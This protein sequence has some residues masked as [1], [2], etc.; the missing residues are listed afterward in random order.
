MANV[1][2][3]EFTT[4]ENRFYE[5]FRTT[6]TTHRINAPNF[7][8]Q[9]HFME[10]LRRTLLLM[11]H[12]HADT[13][14]VSHNDM[15]HMGIDCPDDEGNFFFAQVG[16]NSVTIGDCLNGDGLHTILDYFEKRMQSNKNFLFGVG[17]IIKI[18]TF[19]TPSQFGRSNA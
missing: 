16:G 4:T 13:D 14:G 9:M 6:R 1:Y 17:T 15:L 2:H 19:A 5:N 10:C 11:C 3:Y 7:N 12:N 18:Y 8:Q